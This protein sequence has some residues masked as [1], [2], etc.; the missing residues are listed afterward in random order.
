[1][2]RPPHDDPA[3]Q[4]AADEA[5]R[6]A[7]PLTRVVDWF[8]RLR[9]VRVIRNYGLNRGPLLAAGLSFHSLFAMFA[10]TW[11]GFAVGGLLIKV[12]PTLRD[13]VFQFINRNV[14]GLIE[15]GAGNGVI[16]RGELLE[17]R[18]LG[19]TGAAASVGLLMT[20]L[21]WL[22]SARAAIR[23]IFQLENPQTHLLMLKLKDL[24]LAIGFGLAALISAGLT[25]VGT[26]AL[27][28]FRPYLTSSGTEL[29]ARALGLAVMFLF[30]A[31]VLASLFRVLAGIRIPFRRLVGGVLLG[32]A[33]LAVLKILGG[34][35]L[36]GASGNPLLASF[37]VFIGLMVWFNLVSQVILI[38]ASW[39]AVG[40][41]DAGVSMAEEDSYPPRVG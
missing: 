14:P 31:T 5:A 8:L 3:V 28:L 12:D 7:S 25:A 4:A 40:A 26:Q 30:D 10:A 41:R 20:T 18:V 32:A 33:S 13:G 35:L 23:T 11:L 22:A 17:A 38:S 9:P 34:R 29:A 39:I 16:D 1:M 27:G 24:G 15:S 36:I 19:W 37:A 2:A 21:G 6:A